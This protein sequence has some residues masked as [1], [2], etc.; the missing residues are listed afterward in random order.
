MKNVLM[1]VMNNVIYDSRVKKIT[2]YHLIIKPF[3][4]FIKHYFI[5]AGFLD[6]FQGLVISMVSAYAVRMRYVKLW[7]LRKNQK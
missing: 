3:Y 2:A 1:I 4:R 7:L 5:H 6:G